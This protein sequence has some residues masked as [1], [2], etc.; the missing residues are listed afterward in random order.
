MPADAVTSMHQNVGAAEGSVDHAELQRTHGFSYRTLLGELL[1][2]YVTCQ[3]DIGHSA[4]TLS[5]FSM[6]PH[7]LHFTLLKKL[8]KYLHQTKDWGIIC[9]KPNR[10]A[11][12]PSSP[13]VRATLDN[14]LP[15][16]PT[17][18]PLQLAGFVDATHANDLC[19]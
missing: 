15:S 9:H 19:N 1:C 10:D 7:D 12:L 14:N 13:H 18:E 2:A 8:A 17:L 5:K 16:F 6:S 3:P 11:S 4:I